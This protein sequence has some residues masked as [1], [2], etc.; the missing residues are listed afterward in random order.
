MVEPYLILDEPLT[1][2]NNPLAQSQEWPLDTARCGPM[3][4]TTPQKDKPG[5]NPHIWFLIPPSTTWSPTLQKS[6][7]KWLNNK[8]CQPPPGAHTNHCQ[9]LKVMSLSPRNAQL[10]GP[11]RKGLWTLVLSPASGTQHPPLTH[12]S[13]P[14]QGS[15]GHPRLGAPQHLAGE[16]QQEVARGHRGVSLRGGGQKGPWASGGD[17]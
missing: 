10:Q 14:S 15:Q 12:H 5:W 2:R 1:A 7:P 6:A 9:K 16:G 17:G 8:E 11:S 13:V 3:H 4:T